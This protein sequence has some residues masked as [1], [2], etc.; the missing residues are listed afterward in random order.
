MGEESIVIGVVGAAASITSLIMQLVKKEQP[1]LDPANF[2][3]EVQTLIYNCLAQGDY[4]AD[5]LLKEN[6]RGRD[7]YIPAVMLIKDE[8]QIS[9]AICEKKDT[10]FVDK[11]LVAKLKNQG[12]IIYDNTTY[13]LVGISGNEISIGL[14]KYY[15]NLSNCD[16]FYYQLIDIYQ[17]YKNPDQHVEKW[18]AQLD[19]LIVDKNFD[20]ISASIGCSTLFVMKTNDT[21]KYFIV[22][23]S[24]KK[25][26]VFSKHVTPAFMFQPLKN[27][28]KEE[29]I[30]QLDV[31]Q[32]MMREFGEE[33]LNMTEV[34]DSHMYTSQQRKLA[35][36]PVLSKI[37]ACLDTG[38][39]TFKTLGIS[40]DVFRFRPEILSVL[41]IEDDEFSN[42]FYDNVALNWEC[43][44]I[45]DYDLFDT[46]QYL[47]LLNDTKHPLVSPG[48]A[49]LKLGRD[50]ALTK[51]GAKI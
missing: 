41:I 13:R 33:L 50:Y 51:L 8:V 2:Y 31:K 15:Q 26:D 48:A 34:E 36:H 12:K 32:Q 18:L 21:Y 40:L 1:P 14:S 39:A 47:E 42:L 24:D 49:C 28:S 3:S 19:K 11:E 35:A 45:K 46:E 44:R 23:N 43:A 4:Y 7:I 10:H 38:K 6:F 27:S 25:N 9:K 22:D 16:S 5:N 17:D 30:Q 29:L 20:D 37:N